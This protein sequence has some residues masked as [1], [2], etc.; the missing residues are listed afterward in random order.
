M[1]VPVLV[2]KNLIY[3]VISR[4]NT[5][6]KINAIVD[7]KSNKIICTVINKDFSVQLGNIDTDSE[8]VS[9]YIGITKPP[10]KL[11]HNNNNSKN[12]NNNNNANN[13]GSIR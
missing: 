12:N 2:I 1:E 13:F 10:I 9:N 4:T 5:P 3:Y 8:T 11:F 7:F 6:R